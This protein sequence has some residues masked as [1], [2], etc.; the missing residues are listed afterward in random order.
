MKKIHIF[1]QRAAKNQQRMSDRC[2]YTCLCRG[3][4]IVE[5][6]AVLGYVEGEHLHLKVFSGDDWHSLEFV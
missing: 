2:S 6:K 5:G 3:V 4:D 1:W